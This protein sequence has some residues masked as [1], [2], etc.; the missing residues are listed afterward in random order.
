MVDAVFRQENRR[1]S[2]GNNNSTTREMGI[3]PSVV[4]EV[5]PLLLLLLGVVATAGPPGGGSGGGTGFVLGVVAT[6]RAGGE[7]ASPSFAGAGDDSSCMPP[8]TNVSFLSSPVCKVTGEG[9]TTGTEMATDAEAPTA[10]ASKG[11]A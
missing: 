11:T 1:T 10:F 8:A 2:P 6:A 4:V 9:A 5:V 7:G 3:T